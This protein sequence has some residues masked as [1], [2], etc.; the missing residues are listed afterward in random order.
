MSRSGRWLS[1]LLVAVV[2]VGANQG[3]RLR[4]VVERGND[5]WVR[6]GRTLQKAELEPF[7]AGEALTYLGDILA[8][9][10]DDGVYMELELLGVEYRK[11]EVSPEENTGSVAV[12]ETWRVTWRHLGTDACEVILKPRV[13]RQTYRLQRF[14]RRWLIVGIEEE[15]NLPKIETQECPN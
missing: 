7:F 6:A 11:I 3:A 9:S 1:T 4:D 12:S 14:G 8:S 10:R 5:A 15:P 2:G 13:R